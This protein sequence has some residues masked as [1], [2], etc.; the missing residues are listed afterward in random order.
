MLHVIQVCEYIY[1]TTNL[2]SVKI[3]RC[4]LTMCATFYLEQKTIFHHLK[5]QLNQG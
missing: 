2:H 3:L 5:S 1:E 4:N